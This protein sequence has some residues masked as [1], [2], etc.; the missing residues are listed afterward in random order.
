MVAKESGLVE[1]D[2]NQLPIPSFVQLSDEEILTQNPELAAFFE[3]IEVSSGIYDL[4]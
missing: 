4:P 1:S 2:A 3:M